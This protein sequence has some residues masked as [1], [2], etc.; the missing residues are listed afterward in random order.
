M[1]IEAQLRHVKRDGELSCHQQINR[2]VARAID[3]GA[4]QPGERLP[5]ERRFA[6]LTGVSR[7]TVRIAL[8]SLVHQGY[9]EKQ[10]GSG[11]F[12]KSRPVS[13]G[14]GCALPAVNP[15]DRYQWR[16]LLAQ[17][18]LREVRA[19]GHEDVVYLLGSA[20]DYHQLESD[21]DQG[22]IEGLLSVGL[23]DSVCAALPVVY[24]N[25]LESK[26]YCVN[27]DYASMVRQGVA[28]LAGEGCRELALFSYADDDRQRSISREVF[29]EALR[30][31]G[32]PCRRGRQIGLAAWT[33]QGN[34]ED[35]G[36]RGLEELWRKKHRPDGIVF[37]DDWH[38]LGA[39][40]AL[41][42]K[43]VSVPGEVRLVTH[44]NAGYTLPRPC[45][46][47]LLQIDPGD[48]ARAMVELLQEI[49]DGRTEP[50]QVLV[51][52]TLLA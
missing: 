21:A 32:L 10:T 8:E 27:I 2:I 31:L 51:A 40:Q 19:R 4:L 24:V 9:V 20:E 52:P 22:R 16:V 12:V 45:A 37:A 3:K 39:M 28:H 46:A 25:Q 17:S 35:E 33:G 30:D 15:Y 36:R 43:G 1:G 41:V 13:R 14:I 48:L 6:E 26:A 44:A 49:W 23:L 42:E 29:R 47:A 50:R 7:T 11:I 5:A 34:P 18:I 38:G